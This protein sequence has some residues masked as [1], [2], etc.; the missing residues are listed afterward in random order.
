MHTLFY[1]CVPVGSQCTSSLTVSILRLVCPTFHVNLEK[2]HLSISVCA[3]LFQVRR[4]DAEVH[5]TDELYMG[6]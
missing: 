5:G 3:V 4:G 6:H 2:I 1:D